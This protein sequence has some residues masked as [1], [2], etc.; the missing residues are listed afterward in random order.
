MITNRKKVFYL[1]LG[2]GLIM[3]GYALWIPAKAELAQAF[4]EIAWKKTI[5]SGQMHRPWPWADHYPIAKLKSTRHNIEQIILAGDSGAVMAF[6][7]GENLE[8]KNVPDGSRIISAHRDTHFRFLEHT[9]IGDEISLIDKDGE[10][11]YQVIG[12]QVVDSRDHHLAPE[13]NPN[14]LILVTCF[15]FNA[16]QAGGPLRFVV[17]L[18]P[19]VTKNV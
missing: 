18:K 10:S 11:T 12:H 2:I 4:L 14:G 13:L 15:P 9:E 6:A 8:A 3:V 16:I 7:P 1:S 5:K 19:K 17:T